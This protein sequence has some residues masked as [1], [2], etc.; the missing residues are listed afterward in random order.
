MR[1]HQ[2]IAAAAPVLLAWPAHASA[3][4][5]IAMWGGPEASGVAV[6]GVIAALAWHQLAAHRAGLLTRW[7][8]LHL[9]ERWHHAGDAMR[10]AVAYAR[11]HA[12]LSNQNQ[13]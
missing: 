1:N 7:H 5:V 13:K 6:V 11:S 12:H 10:H 9:A 3:A 4:D 8:H 2:L